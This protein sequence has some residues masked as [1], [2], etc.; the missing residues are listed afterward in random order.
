MRPL[1]FLLATFVGCQ[2]EPEPRTAIP[3]LTVKRAETAIE[4]DGRLDEVVWRDA[5]RTERFVNT[6]NGAYAEPSAAARMAWD[7]DHL[8]VAFE[9]DDRDLRCSF[10][11][12]D[13]HL[14]E[15]DAVELMIDPDG[16]GENYFEIQVSPTEL[17]FDTRFDSR[18]QPQPF[19][20]LNWQSNLRAAVVAQGEANDDAVDGGYVAEI[21]IPFSSFAV[22]ATPAE[23]P[24]PD[25]T[26][27]I[28]L[29][30]LDAVEGGQRGVGWSPPLVGDYHVPDR[31]GR[32]T[33]QQ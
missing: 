26:W 15:Q 6:M 33:F 24:G 18:R 20:H 14:W 8:Y 32:V 23:P 9:V 28:A 4:I 5:N 10:E 17:V 22:G 1:V 2:C 21:A 25:T 7:D 27:R 30:V 11:N 16:D 12:H 31:F 13:D 3:T 19:G 29:Y